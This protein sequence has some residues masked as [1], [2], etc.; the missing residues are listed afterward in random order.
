MLDSIMITNFKS[1]Q[2]TS[3]LSMECGDSL[4]SDVNTLQ[5]QSDKKLLNSVYVLGA[6]L[7][8]KT[9][10]M[11]VFKFLVSSIKNSLCPGNY[12]HFSNKSNISCFAVYFVKNNKFFEYKLIC[13]ES[14]VLEE[15]LWTNHSLVFSRDYNRLEISG[16]SFNGYPKNIRTGQLALPQLA[17]DELL[18]AKEAFDWFVNDIV[19][20]EYSDFVMKETINEIVTN[21]EELKNKITEFLQ[22]VDLIHPYEYFDLETCWQN[23]SP[24]IKRLLLLLIHSLTEQNKNKVLLVDDFDIGLHDELIEVLIM[25]FT[26]WNH[27]RQYI[28]TTCNSNILSKNLR[29][30]QIYFVN[31]NRNVNKNRSYESEL[32]SLFDFD[33]INLETVLEDYRL[34]IYDAKPI[35]N[36][37]Y[38]QNIIYDKSEQEL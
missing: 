18:E 13:K 17:N 30:D 10:L 1:F 24:S 12:S 16:S 22:A 35:I 27:D 15:K 19:F 34:G 11:Q 38:L 25:L 2:Q 26:K 33:E 5:V 32:Y 28:V 29:Q 3:T 20:V 4:A 8:G 23:I 36:Y 9:N 37:P 7:S 14:C 21:N 31:K 6:N